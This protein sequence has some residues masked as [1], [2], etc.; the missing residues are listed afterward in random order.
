MVRVNVRSSSSTS[1]N[2]VS[3][4]SASH[5]EGAGVSWLTLGTPAL[6]ENGACTRYDVE[7]YVPPT[8]RNLTIDALSPV[9][10]HTAFDDAPRVLHA[11]TVNIRNNGGDARYS[12]ILKGEKGLQVDELSV[13]SKSGYI[14]GAL[15]VGNTTDIDTSYSNTVSKLELIT[16]GYDVDAPTARGA[17]AY[18]NAYTGSGLSTFTLTNAHSRPII[19]S[20]SSTSRSSGDGDLRLE[21]G[22]SKF[23]GIVK[24]EAK[25]YSMRGVESEAP[26]MGDVP[27]W[28]GD[29]D[30]G[31]YLSVKTGGWVGLYF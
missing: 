10:L 21:Y 11:L 8:L 16:S 17:P 23:N 31:D 6:F 15:S 1:F 22:G 29:K 4:D 2:G 25:G 12:N 14:V 26:H 9:H 30:G 28:V 19:A 13:V 27:R 18:I 24:I 3:I 7:V 5:E 20:H